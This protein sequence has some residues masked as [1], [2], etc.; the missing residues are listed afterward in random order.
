MI[1]G[2]KNHRNILLTAFRGT[3]AE[4]L[5]KGND[6]CPSLY[7][8]NDRK[9]DSQNLI[10]ELSSNS[11]DHV[12]SFG[13]KPNIKN[14]VYIETA[15]RKGEDL[16]HTNADYEKIKDI[17]EKNALVT[18]ISHNAGTSFCNELYLNGLKY[19]Y[20]NRLDIKMIFIHVPFMKNI[21]DFSTF[22]E[23]IFLAIS[24]FAAD[25]LS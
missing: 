20:G 6:Y 2:R 14:K 19:I 1:I 4:A 21:S 17:L 25:F 23:R 7:L 10:R 13:Q 11:F 15:A 3:S 5:I 16:V 22:R 18:K 12:I 8:P 9:K 24:D